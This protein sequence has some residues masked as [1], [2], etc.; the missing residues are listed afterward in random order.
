MNRLFNALRDF[1][2]EGAV[3][4][5][6]LP[7]EIREAGRKNW[8][9]K[10]VQRITYDVRKYSRSL[11]VIS[12]T[13]SVLIFIPLIFIIVA[14]IGHRAHTAYGP[15][16]GVFALYVILV[17]LISCSLLWSVI[18]IARHVRSLPKDTV[19]SC[20]GRYG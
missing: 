2:A 3:L 15:W 16:Y 11:S 4:R 20:L 12:T 10:T 1:I 9:P 13:S 5:D 6:S 18:P 14:L 17:G 7:N 8:D 19:E